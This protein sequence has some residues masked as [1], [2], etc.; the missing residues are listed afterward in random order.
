M[1]TRTVTVGERSWSYCEP[2]PAALAERRWALVRA[3][4]LD[5]LTGQPVRQPLRVTTPHTELVTH[6]KPGAIVGVSAQPAKRFPNLHA[7]PTTVALQV[8]AA[9][10]LTRQLA[11][12]IGPFPTF[13]DTFDP[14]DLGDLPLHRAPVRAQGRAMRVQGIGR[15]PLA[16][17]DVA[18]T[19]VWPSFPPRDVDPITVMESP[20][21]VH[22]QPGLYRERA[23]TT[24][25][26]AVDLVA[27]IGEEK[28][29]LATV[30]E[31]DTQLLLS[32]RVNLGPNDVLAIAPDDADRAEYIPVTSV[33]GASTD[34][35]SA[36]V[37]LRFPTAYSHATSAV[38]VRATVQNP[39]AQN[40]VTRD[41]LGAD[42]TLFVD[43]LTDFD[44]AAAVEISSGADPEYHRVALYAT[45]SDGHGDWRLPPLSRV[46]QFELTSSRADLP[47]PLVQLLS[48]DYDQP[49][50]HH[51]IVF[52]Q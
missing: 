13:P 43:A 36:R 22:L 45:Q 17:V 12:A 1:S 21:L 31:G 52:P 28:R 26:R 11:A 7:A 23:T 10:Y 40:S 29:L 8:S 38:A 6:S 48:P 42:P 9:R 33:E 32:D 24:T 2:R 47:Q 5:E 46:A 35:Q 25:V 41:G 49:A 51:D 39:G 15:A 34:D 14:T 4:M 50:Y 30:S 44:G 18:I 19:G 3:R 27:A 16:G 37:T 20:T